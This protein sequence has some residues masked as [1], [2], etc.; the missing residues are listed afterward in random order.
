MYCIAWALFGYEYKDWNFLLGWLCVF[1]FD[2]T[3]IRSLKRR[4]RHIHK[5][6]CCLTQVKEREKREDV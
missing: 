4:T 2:P 1:N 3:V 6:F 5:C